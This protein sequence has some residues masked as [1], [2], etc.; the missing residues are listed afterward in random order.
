MPALEIMM[1]RIPRA[2]RRRYL[3]AI[4]RPWFRIPNHNLQEQAVIAMLENTHPEVRCAGRACVLHNPTDHPQRR[5]PL[6]WRNDRVM[7]ERICPCGIGHP[8]ADQYSY[9]EEIGAIHEGVHG[10]CGIKDHC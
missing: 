3:L 1:Y 8:D 6:H 5:F 4:G 9:W 7:F 2:T 10:C